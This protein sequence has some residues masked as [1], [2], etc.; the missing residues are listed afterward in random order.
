MLT[1]KQAK[2]GFT[3][4]EL[5]IVIAII[6]IL[7]G[8]VLTNIQG[9]Q[10]KARDATRLGDIDSVATALEI[11][12]NENGYYPNTFNATPGDAAQLPGIQEDALI[13]ERGG[14]TMVMATPVADLAAAKTAAAAEVDDDTA[15]SAGYVYVPFPTGCTNDCTGFVVAA[16][17]EQDDDNYEEE[18]SLNQ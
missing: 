7:A 8:L 9:A 3:I 14:Q 13:D 16:Y 11:Y 18:V 15:T 10:A 1:L 2:K 17:L 6:V 5:L 12:H 4:I